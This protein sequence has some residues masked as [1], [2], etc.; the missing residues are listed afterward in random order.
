VQAK[1]EF[2]IAGNRAGKIICKLFR[3]S[4]RCPDVRKWRWWRDWRWR[5]YVRRGRRIRRISRRHRRRHWHG[6]RRCRSWRLWRVL[7]W[8]PNMNIIC[9]VPLNSIAGLH[10]FL[11]RLQFGPLALM[12]VDNRLGR[13]RGRSHLRQCRSQIRQFCVRAVACVTI[14]RNERLERIRRQMH[15]FHLVLKI[16][17][18]RGEQGI[19]TAVQQIVWKINSAR[20]QPNCGQ[21]DT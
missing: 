3:Q 18:R 15:S 17:N 5:R 4:R 14:G 1:S 7:R 12:R 21:I 13:W 9:A 16:G 11:I 6:R 8:N 10:V 20:G 19:I 2:D